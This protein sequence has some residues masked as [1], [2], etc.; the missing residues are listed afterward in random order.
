[1]WYNVV[2]C[3]GYL[4]LLPLLWDISESIA[5]LWPHCSFAS[6]TAGNSFPPT[7]PLVRPLELVFVYSIY[8]LRPPPPP[9]PLA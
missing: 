5:G 2:A 9:L 7:P 4:Y 8:D 3:S 1:M 6:P